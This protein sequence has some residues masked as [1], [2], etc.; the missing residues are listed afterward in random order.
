LVCPPGGV[1]LVYDERKKMKP[2]DGRGPLVSERERGRGI[3]P[4]LL[5]RLRALTNGPRPRGKEGARPSGQNRERERFF[6][7]IYIFSN[8]LSFVPK[9][10]SKPFKITFEIFLSFRQ[11][12]HVNKN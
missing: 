11:I 7:F 1:Q 5:G 8:F 4:R 3:G 2:A 9:S 12:T 10:F 6:F